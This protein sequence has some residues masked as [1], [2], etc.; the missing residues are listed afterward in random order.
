M[1]KINRTK[2]KNAILYF[3]YGLKDNVVDELKPDKA[4]IAKLLYYLDFINFRDRK[5]SITGTIY[6]KQSFGPLPKDYEEMI[7][8]LVLEG[9]LEASEKIIVA[10]GDTKI[11]TDVLLAKERPEIDSVF[12]KDEQILARKILTYYR[13]WTAE[14]LSAKSHLE[15][16]WIKAK[17]GASLDFKFAND[18]DD[19]NKAREE[20]YRKEEEAIVGAIRGAS[21]V[22]MEG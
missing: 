13:G 7:G 21:K 11:E 19:F 17:Y 12:N 3:S 15:A 10:K 6:Y 14:E 1:N 18:I 20:S 9:K 8:E 5:K 22:L 4:K 16:P 2:Y